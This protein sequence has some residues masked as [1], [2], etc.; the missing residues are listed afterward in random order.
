M[1]IPLHMP[2]LHIAWGSSHRWAWIFINQVRMVRTSVCVCVCVCLFVC[3]CVCVCVCV[4][5]CVCVHVCVSA[6]KA[7]N[8]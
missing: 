3:V 4:Y 5:V 8:N 7:I 6:P 2:R 1:W